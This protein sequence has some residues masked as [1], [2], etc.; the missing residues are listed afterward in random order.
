MLHLDH[1]RGPHPVRCRGWAV[2][3]SRS[4]RRLRRLDPPGLALIGAGIGTALVVANAMGSVADNPAEA[5][6]P[7]A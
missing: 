5:A 3:Q 7:A 2:D 1:G 6:L 4:A